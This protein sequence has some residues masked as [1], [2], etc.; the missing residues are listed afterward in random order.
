MIQKIKQGI[1]ALVPKYGCFSVHDDGTVLFEERVVVPKEG[2]LREVIMKEARDSKLSIHPGSTKMYQDLKQSFW[3]TRMK[4]DVA[5]FVSQCDVCRRVKAQHQKP[6]GLLQPLE[7]LE[8]KWDHIEMDFVTGFPR[9]QK[10]NNALSSLITCPR[11]PIFCLSKKL[12]QLGSWQSCTRIIAR[13]SQEDK[14]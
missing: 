7:I 13:H 8:W 1:V 3:W 6:A 2:D 9:S 14:F 11:L 12:S 5:R 10:A 4:R